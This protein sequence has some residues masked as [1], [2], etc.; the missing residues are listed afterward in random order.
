M[1]NMLLAGILIA[2]VVLLLIVI[3]QSRPMRDSTVDASLAKLVDS[4]KDLSVV[5]SQ[6]SALAVGQQALV[7]NINGL[8]I[9]LHQLETKLARATGDVKSSISRDVGETKRL[10]TELR[11]RFE[12]Q[13]KLDDEI[14]AV[15]RRIERVLVGARSR[16]ASGENILADAFG[17]FPPGMIDRD[18]RIGGKVVE[19]A[20]ILPNNK[21]M[22]ID[23]KWSSTE[24]IERIE[25]ETDPERIKRLE[26]EVEKEVERKVGEVASYIDPSSTSNVAIAAVPDAVYGFCKKVHIEAFKKGVLIMAY[27]MVIPYVLALYHLHLQMARTVDF[28]NVEAYLTRIERSLDEMDRILE[29]KIARVATMA[30]NAYTECKQILGSIRAAASY[31]RELPAGEAQPLENRGSGES[32][33]SEP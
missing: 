26:A 28:D 15:T 6:V 10:L 11:T 8:E 3:R 4:F 22:P 19:Y 12:D 29:N 5:Q 31:L 30:S 13:T 16:G 24:T 2:V 9:T 20:I 17:E 33:A 27:S 23:S 21:R 7:Q 32:Q 18:F 25:K 1:D 14:H